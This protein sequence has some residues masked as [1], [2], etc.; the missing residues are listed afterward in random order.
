MTVIYVK[1]NYKIKNYWWPSTCK[2]N[3]EVAH[4]VK[5]NYLTGGTHQGARYF[6]FAV[7][8]PC[9]TPA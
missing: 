4:G 3:G 5:T 8:N 1:W 7:S 2:F 9:L 6:T